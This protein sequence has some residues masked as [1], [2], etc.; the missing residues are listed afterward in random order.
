MKILIRPL[1]TKKKSND[2]GVQRSVQEFWISSSARSVHHI[3]S[4]QNVL[5]FLVFL[6]HRDK[7]S[8]VDTYHDQRDRGQKH[9]LKVHLRKSMFFQLG[10]KDVSEISSNGAGDVQYFSHKQRRWGFTVS[11][12][13]I[14][15]GAAAGSIFFVRPKIELGRT[16]R[17][18]LRGR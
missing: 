17:R 14:R 16:I 15:N 6:A 3:K 13:R 4:M 2:R 11:F 12:V 5:V 10:F 8:D 18:A 7:R 1:D 9:F